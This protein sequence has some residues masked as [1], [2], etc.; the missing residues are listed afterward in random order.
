MLLRD[1]G[2][3]LGRF[4]GCRRTRGRARGH[5]GTT[6]GIGWHGGMSE[7]HTADGQPIVPEHLPQ[8]TDDEQFEVMER[9]FRERYEDP[10]ERTPYD[11]EE[12][13]YIWIW[14]GPYEANEVLGD[15]FGAIVNQGLIDSLVQSLESDCF[16]WAP[17][18]DED[19][20]AD[21]IFAD[22]AAISD[23][24]ANFLSGIDDVGKL[25]EADV[26]GETAPCLFRLLY[27]NVITLLET[28]LSD[29]FSNT[30]LSDTDLRRKLIENT[31]EFGEQKLSV[32]DI[33]KAVDN[34]DKMVQ[35]HLSRI[36][37]HNLARVSKMYRVV[38]NVK[39]PESTPIYRAIKNR[40]DLVHRNGK[41]KDGE[42]IPIDKGH[43]FS[44]ASKAEDFV[45]LVDEELQQ[46]R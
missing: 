2:K 39:F 10:A 15:E 25:V 13:G 44:L 6:A 4:K 23:Y 19:D 45:K 5:A 34:V 3:I 42:P 26:D 8:L 35:E 28:F 43:V 1:D 17:T 46:E 38:L 30:V 16:E 40:H 31:P 18:E 14:G 27:I 24:H 41:T 22:I 21:E 7:Y 11:S 20:Y 32:S 9:W 33:F 29:A 12:G 36:V 37:W